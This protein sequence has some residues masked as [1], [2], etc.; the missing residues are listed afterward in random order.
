MS[1]NQRENNR[2]LRNIK[3]AG[4]TAK[5]IDA[6]MDDFI[7]KFIK[8]MTARENDC[9]DNRALRSK[10]WTVNLASESQTPV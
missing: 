7:A 6:G 8:K 3:H 9:F 1:T 5:C 2:R 10:P 4:E